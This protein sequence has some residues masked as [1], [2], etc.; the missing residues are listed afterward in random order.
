MAGTTNNG[1]LNKVV[2]ITAK[3]AIFIS[4]MVSEVEP[5]RSS[6]SSNL[7]QIT[8]KF[9]TI[10]VILYYLSNRIINN[11]ILLLII[12]YIYSAGIK[13]DVITLLNHLGLS[14][15][16]NVLQKELWDIISSSKQWVKQ[17]SINCQLVRISN[18]FK[19]QENQ[20]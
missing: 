4:S 18:N 8:I 9:L 6:Q 14:V 19:L 15:L 3:K 17:Q 20:S 7:P 11:Y 12:V 5:W 2:N 13:V 10:L 1:P 16:Y